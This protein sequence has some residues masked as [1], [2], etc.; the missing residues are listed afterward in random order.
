[1][2]GGPSN[3]P[4]RGIIPP[5]VTPLAGPDEL[6]VGGLERVIE[7]IL[8]GGV[9]GL[10]ILGTTGEGP[11]LSYKLRREL[12]RRTCA[13]VAGRVP[14]LVGVTDSA[15]PEMLQMTACAAESGANAIVVAPPYY[16]MLGQPDLL[17]LIESAAAR[18]ALPMYL[19]NQPE[20]T[21]ISFSAETV[22]SA[23][24]IP[25]VAGIK[26]SSGDIG[27]L[28][29]ILE[30]VRRHP[31]FSVLV[32]P[33]HL[34][35][36]ALRSGAHGGVPGGAN[37]YPELPVRLYQESM[38]GND[39]AAGELQERIITLGSP[40]WNTGEPVSGSIR[41]LKTALNLLGLCSAKPAWPYIESSA[42]E[43]RQIEEHLDKHG[44]LVR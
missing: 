8:R 20:L 23:L 4:V 25:N 43:R 37:L 28:K 1:M 14:V 44:M 21:K 38:R 36:E 26:D 12:I 7:R 6:D 15:W 17:R 11:A 39:G 24:S 41:R 13:Q 29:E 30:R 42:V 22:E 32:G 31:A 34:L 40:I 19:Y 16:F 18:S 10:F 27:Y 3:A 33:E 9:H 35:W 2:T 5:M